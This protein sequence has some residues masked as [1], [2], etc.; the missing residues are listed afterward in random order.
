MKRNKK[1]GFYQLTFGSEYFAKQIAKN[2]NK[3]YPD[4]AVV[5]NDGCFITNEYWTK[6][7]NYVEKFCNTIEK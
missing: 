2:I 3:D 4:C 7:R 6:C 1:A 5:E